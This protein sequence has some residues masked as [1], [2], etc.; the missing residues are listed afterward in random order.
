[1]RVVIPGRAKRT[2]SLRAIAVRRTASLRFAYGEAIQCAPAGALTKCA[3]LAA[4]AA[5]LIGALRAQLDCFASL[6][7]TAGL[8]LART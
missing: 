5:F 7:M 2:A 4:D 8:R 3:E 6:A 1:M